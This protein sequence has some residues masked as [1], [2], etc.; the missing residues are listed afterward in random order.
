MTNQP[1]EG[2]VW[3]NAVRQF[4][5]DLLPDKLAP[6][7][8]GRI[9]PEYQSPS[10]LDDPIAEQEST[11]E[12]TRRSRE[13]AENRATVAEGKAGRL[14]QASLAL[15][16]L[17][18]TVSGYQI[19]YVRTHPPWY[20][21]FLMVPS[22]LAIFFLAWSVILALEI[23]RPGFYYQPTASG[24][25]VSK[26]TV[27]ARVREEEKGRQLADWTA[28]HKFSTL[29]DARS[30]FSR[31]LVSLTI[32]ALLAA[33]TIP[34]GDPFPVPT[35]KSAQSHGQGL[36]KRSELG[37]PALLRVRQALKVDQRSLT[38]PVRVD[39]GELSIRCVSAA[40]TLGWKP[41]A[42]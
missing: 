14:V 18:I 6:T 32:A 41:P 4:W 34:A 12:I 15:L 11:V 21:W 38:G 3:P 30:R 26:G 2:G 19:G 8:S 20:Y 27:K 25:A 39:A 5:W 22:T 13:E 31:G 36:G 35:I 40:D 9:A 24:L 1:H 42:A 16:A 17:A 33:F 10:W 29:L 7:N 23:D 37:W 28:R